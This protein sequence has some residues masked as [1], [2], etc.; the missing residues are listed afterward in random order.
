MYSSKLYP[1]SCRKVISHSKRNLA[2]NCTNETIGWSLMSNKIQLGL[3]RWHR[4]YFGRDPGIPV[5][6]QYC[7]HLITQL[8]LLRFT[9][10]YNFLLYHTMFYNLTSYYTFYFNSLSLLHP[11]NCKYKLSFHI[12]CYCVIPHRPDICR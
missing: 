10:P 11:Y 9:I 4:Q 6:D 1:F 5:V 3:R 7:H 2:V 8:F 12:V